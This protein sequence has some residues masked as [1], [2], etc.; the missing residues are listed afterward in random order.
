MGEPQNSA[1]PRSRPPT[2]LGR[3]PPQLPPALSVA[4][5]VGPREGAG[6]QGH[7]R[8]SSR[9]AAPHAGP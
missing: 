5:S 7:T 2:R 9:V 8:L 6:C 3:L 1:A 4:P